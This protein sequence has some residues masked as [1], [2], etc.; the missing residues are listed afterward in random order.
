MARDSGYETLVE[1]LLDQKFC[2]GDQFGLFVTYVR[3]NDP[4]KVH[5]GPDGSFAA[6]DGNDEIIAEGSGAQDLYD[7]LV[8]KTVIPGHPEARRG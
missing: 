6:F 3:E 2:A 5:V 8:A 4:L 7:I 1:A